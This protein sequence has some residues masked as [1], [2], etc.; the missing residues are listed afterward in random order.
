MTDTIRIPEPIQQIGFS[1]L[2]ESI[3]SLNLQKALFR[4]VGEMNISEIDNELSEYVVPASLSALAQKG[5]RGEVVFPVPC[6]LR[7]NP[8]LL[9][10]YRMVLGFS[11]KQFYAK[12]FGLSKA[13]F[14]NMEEKGVAPEE[15]VAFIPELCRALIGSANDLLFGLER[16]NLSQQF[17]HELCLIT[18]GTQFRGGTNNKIGQAGIEDV[19]KCIHEIV[20]E[21]VVENN[22]KEILLKNAAGRIVLIQFAPDPDIIIRERRAD[23]SF[24]N[25]VAIEVKAGEDAS[26][27]FNRIGE[28][29]K[30]HL[31]ARANGFHECWTVINVDRTD[32]AKAKQKSQ[33]TD[34]FY[35]LSQLKARSGANFEDFRENIISLTGI[36][37]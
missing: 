20:A 10:Y 29:E 14:L 7:K 25:K 22:E 36:P 15:A 11:K 23:N 5:M 6:L 19:F 31:T 28:A 37:Y 30:S 2:L 27:V 16:E 17:L 3:K 21:H 13:I 32:M 24:T 35:F 4:T 8:H 12:S 18:L 9:G 34:K 26:N 1:V 33:S